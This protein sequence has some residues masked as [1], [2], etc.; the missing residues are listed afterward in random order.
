MPAFEISKIL[1]C[2]LDDAWEAVADFPSR[3]IHNSRYRRADLPDGQEPMPG[4]RILLHIGRDR[5]T[6]IVTA[7]QKPSS[8]SHRAI[9]PGFWVEY[10]YRIRLCDELDPGYTN[11][12]FGLA[13]ISIRS[14]YGGWL[15]SLI[16]KLRPG[17]CRRY[18]EDEL[19]AIVSAAESVAAEP[20][21]DT[22]ADG[23]PPSGENDDGSQR[24]S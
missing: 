16:A 6:S 2:V 19:A 12:D 20:I 5:F 4:H 9:G 22:Q 13:F 10:S 18:L 3:T 8:L 7:V 1:P 24:N 21:S 15:G 11:E 14:E 23:Q 17:A